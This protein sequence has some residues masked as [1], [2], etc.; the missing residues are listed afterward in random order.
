[1][2]YKAPLTTST[3]WGVC[4]VDGTSITATN[5][6]ISINAVPP[7]S[8]NYGFFYDTTTQT[9]PVASAV[10]PVSWDTIPTFNQVI[11]NPPTKLTVL[12]AGTYTK[13]FTVSLQKTSPGAPTV[14]SIWLRYSPTIAGPSVDVVES[15]QDIE[16]PNQVALLFVT[17]GYTLDM[18][19]NSYL[20][21]CWS[22]PDTSVQL[23]A[24]PATVGPVRPAIPSAKITLTRIS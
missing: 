15:R 6:I 10:N 3:D 1:M 18:V 5:G 4:R 22:C 12:N 14:A 23:A 2:G 9:N 13:V 8:L 19:A 16:V 21:M 17:G 24:A 11:L 7:P 20:E